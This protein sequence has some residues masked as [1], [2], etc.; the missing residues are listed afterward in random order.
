VRDCVQDMKGDRGHFSAKSV[1]SWVQRGLPL[2]LVGLGASAQSAASS[3]AG[4]SGSPALDPTTPAR[5]SA[6]VPGSTASSPPLAPL[7]A[8]AVAR[9]SPGLG[10]LS[11]PSLPSSSLVWTTLS[12]W[13]EVITYGPCSPLTHCAVCNV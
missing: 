11:S 5:P 12:A 10:P 4:P 13:L 1:L 8:P 9:G 7:G 2:R 6:T 3:G